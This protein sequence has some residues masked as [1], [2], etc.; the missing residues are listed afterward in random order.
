[1]KSP[2]W[3][4][5]KAWGVFC[6]NIS[7]YAPWTI[8]LDIQC[9]LTAPRHGPLACLH[10][11]V[12]MSMHGMQPAGAV[13][14][15]GN[16]YDCRIHMF[17]QKRLLTCVH[18]QMSGIACCLPGKPVV[19][20]LAESQVHMV[21]SFLFCWS[22]QSHILLSAA[23][24]LKILLT[25]LQGC[26]PE[27][28]HLI[29]MLSKPFKSWIKKEQSEV[30]SLSPAAHIIEGFYSLTPMGHCKPWLTQKARR[31]SP[32]EIMQFWYTTHLDQCRRKQGRWE[33]ICGT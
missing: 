22:C 3:Y 12:L 9:R 20:D 19:G 14:W 15:S 8:I 30:C 2:D 17:F 29:I 7:T 26:G 21:A 1:M 32:Q 33:E 27:P 31:Y 6:G 10:M 4:R 24:W 18:P 11:V 25:I 23:E 5:A 13:S 16:G 28:Q